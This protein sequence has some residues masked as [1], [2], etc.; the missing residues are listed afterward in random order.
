M[1][2]FIVQ[3]AGNFAAGGAVL[4]VVALCLRSVV[5]T[6]KSGGC[7]GGCAGCELKGGCG[8]EE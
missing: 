5:K 2:D 1:L 3:N 6:H 4:I 8:K 7:P